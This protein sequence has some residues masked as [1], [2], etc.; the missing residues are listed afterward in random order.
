MHKES[1]DLMKEFLDKQD[2]TKELNVLE[3]GSCRITGRNY[4]ELTENGNWKYTGLD[5]APGDNV[6]LLVEDPYNYPLEDNS[7]DII[8]SGQTLEHV[9]YIWLWIKELHR[10]TKKGGK[11]CVI[12]PSRGKRHHRPDYW[13]IQPDGMKALL[14]Y[15]GFK[16]IEVN[17]SLEGIW[18]DCVGIAKK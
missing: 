15:A 6:T 13:R 4:R 17:L 11:V 9:K 2:K 14:E 1:Y 5:L 16:D 18:Q 7:F 8:I 10:L 12:A 3:V